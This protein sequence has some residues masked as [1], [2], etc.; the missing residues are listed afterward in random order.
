MFDMNSG[1]SGYSMSNRAREAYDEGEKPKSKWTKAEIIAV[2]EE[3]ARDNEIGV[4]L[5]VLKKTPCK[6]LK[7]V[8]LVK[9]SWHHTSSY[10]NRTNFYSVDLDKLSA[11]T[12]ETFAN[13]VEW[14]GMGKK[15]T[16]NVYRGDIK[17]LEWSGTRKHPKAKE[18]IVRDVNI[19]EKGCYYI[20][21]D[22][23][24]KELMKKKIG[25]NGTVVIRYH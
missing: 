25:S 22:D 12:E 24:G 10:A 1:Y 13:A 8:L 5:S 19:E 9:T 2:I 4:P 23:A 7:D 17:Y 21:T 15:S 14:E 18:C 20:V 11:L 16:P 6:T 3:Y